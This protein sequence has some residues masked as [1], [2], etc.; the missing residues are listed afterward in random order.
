M[1]GIVCF[2]VCLAGDLLKRYAVMWNQD[3]AG[4]EVR[5]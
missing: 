2:Q 3:L 5:C 1:A 4:S